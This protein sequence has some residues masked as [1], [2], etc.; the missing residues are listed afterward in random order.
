MKRKFYAVFAILS[1]CFTTLL[2]LSFF[3]MR[4]EIIFYQNEAKEKETELVYVYVESET[5]ESD[6]DI[7][8]WLV[9][10][11][12]GKI[13]I[14]DNDGKLLQI[15]DTYIKTLPM[16]DR[17]LLREGIEICDEASLYSIIEAYS[18]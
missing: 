1:I 13:G 2:T 7:K 10:E 11:Y 18:D 14:F 15:I 6:T 5:I 4:K 12:E 17:S 8:K 16:E 9:K 3:S